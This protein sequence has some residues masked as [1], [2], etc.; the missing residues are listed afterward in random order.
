MIKSRSIYKV[1]AAGLISLL[2]HA[3]HAKPQRIVSINLCTDQLA[4]L[5]ADRNNIKS[6]S[7][8]ATQKNSS[9]MYRE[10]AGIKQNYGK[11]EDILLMQPD[12]I[13]AGTYT[14][15]PAV[16]LLRRLGFNIVEIPIA[17]TLDDIRH[18]IM[19]VARAVGEIQRGERLISSF[20]QRLSKVMSAQAEQ[21]PVAVFYREN[22]YTTGGNT[23]ANTILETAGFSNLA[24]QLGILGGGHLSLETL[25]AKDPDIIISGKRRSKEG[26]VAMAA[27]QHPAFKKFKSK[28]QTIKISDPLWVCGT[29]FV[30]DAVENLAAVRYQMTSY[31]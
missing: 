29:P 5:I 10:A 11:A 6:V 2:S 24:T 9:V 3:I 15:R 16:F 22:G 25:I 26:S 21:R 20:N 17:K 1:V 27:F 19:I 12:L 14:S 4:M 18:N 13:L 7:Y 23:L 28:K 30:L 31:K 8:L